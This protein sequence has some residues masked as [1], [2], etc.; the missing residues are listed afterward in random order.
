MCP[1]AKIANRQLNREEEINS[2]IE[3]AKQEWEVTVDSLSELICLLDKN[4]RI[5]RANLAVERWGLEDVHRIKGKSIHSLLHPRCAEKKCEIEI[6]QDKLWSQVKRGETALLETVDHVNKKFLRLKI[7][8][9]PENKN[10]PMDCFAIGIIEDIGEH[11]KI[12][13]QLV[14]LYKHV[15]AINRRVSILLEITKNK[16]TENKKE[17]LDQLLRSAL[18]LSKSHF[19]ALYKYNKIENSFDLLSS[20]VNA[21]A[22]NRKRPGQC[23][24]LEFSQKLLSQLNGKSWMEVSCEELYP[25][26]LGMAGAR[27]S[28]L[29]FPLGKDGVV[30]GIIIFGFPLG[31][32][33]S[34]QDIDFLNIFTFQALLFLVNNN[35]IE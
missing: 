18:E 34:A 14:D 16:D 10:R 13:S 25:T 21:R 15:G 32:I 35:I 17:V 1:N 5:L 3:V 7:Q 27:G 30:S 22:K 26:E 31:S 19:V 6:Y 12:E 23:L 33:I 29:L 11:K 9:I 24:S 8:P 28:F 2:L 4:G 20:Q